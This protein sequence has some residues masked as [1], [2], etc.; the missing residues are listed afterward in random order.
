MQSTSLPASS[1]THAESTLPLP[2]GLLLSLM[3]DQQKGCAQFFIKLLWRKQ[4]VEWMKVAC[5]CRT[6]DSILDEHDVAQVDFLKVDCEGGEYSIL[7]RRRKRRLAA[8]QGLPWSFMNFIPRTIIV[9]SSID[10]ARRASMLRSIA[11]C[12]NACF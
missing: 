9:A 11:R 2:N 7:I 6:I 1:D 10:F 8:S 5:P 12:L 4:Q 3:S